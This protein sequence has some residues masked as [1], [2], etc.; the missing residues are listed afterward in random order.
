MGPGGKPQIS[1]AME[2]LARLSR[3]GALNL[4]P[5]GPRPGSS[6][7]SGVWAKRCVA[8][9]V[10]ALDC[11]LALVQPIELVVVSSRRTREYRLWRQLLQEH[12]YLGAG[13]LCGHQLRYLIKGACGWLGAA[14]FSAAARRVA[15][16]DKWIGWGEEARRE[17]LPLVISN[18]RFLILPQVRVG[19]LASHV[20]AQ[21]TQ[22]VAQDWQERFGYRPV[23]VESFVELSR[24]RGTCYQAANWKLAGVSSG[25]GRQD[26]THAQGLAKKL[27][28]V[29]PL[30]AEFGARLRQVPEKRRLAP[31]PVAV[32]EPPAP[33]RNWLEEEFGGVVLPDERLKGRLQSLAADFF[34]RPGMNLPQ[35]CGSRAKTKAAYRFLD[36]K[37]VNLNTLLAG[38]YQATRLRAAQEPVLLAVQDTTELNYS[39]HPATEMLGPL[40]DKPKVVGL[41]LHETI[42]YNLKG[43]PLGLLATQCWA[44]DPDQPGKKKQRYELPIEAKESSKWLVSHAAAS[45]LQEQCPGNLVVSVGDREADVYELFVQAQ[46]RPKAA[47]VLVRARQA[48]RLAEESAEQT[49]L[50]QT[51]R[52]SPKAGEIELRVP[53]QKNRPVRTAQ[54]EVHFLEVTLRAP[55]RKPELGKVRCWAI[56]AREITVPPA[57]VE[58]IE[59]LLLTN[60]PVP[61][62]AAALE[63]IQWYALR[64]QIEVYHRVLKSGCKIEQRQLGNAERIEA[65][66]AIDLVVAWRIAHLTKLGREV[67][68]LPCT[69]YFEEVQWQAMLV[70]ATRQLPPA[71]PP[72]LREMV[73]L[74]ALRLGGFLGRKSDGEPG[75]TVIWRGLQRL[76]D[77]TQ[78][79]CA[80]RGL[81]WVPPTARELDSS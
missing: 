74:M 21:L 56:C 81:P 10:P 27:L 13:P 8:E 42:A 66:L 19:N 15:D 17:N 79:Y 60:V 39:A 14:A 6:L 57:G 16:R 76:D 30:C 69:V 3:S 45:Q 54:L 5:A 31:L 59:W 23:L 70:Y 51:V 32:P 4:P 73:R 63:K 47:K 28:Y 18:S 40:T 38:H 52:Q 48:R 80:M 46:Q 11:A 58:P 25:R 72:S 2:A 36:H 34:A 43:T 1:V 65:C 44:R 33:P 35:A 75:A 64:F 29:Y 41:L 26:R 22:Q 77:I 49:E 24:F 7:A 71:K 12:H 53:R 68:D 9:E 55:K 37:A 20:L 61:T 50:W 67:P 62:L 78:M